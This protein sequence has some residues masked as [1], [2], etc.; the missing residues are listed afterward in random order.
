MAFF[1]ARSGREEQSFA[2]LWLSA[3]AFAPDRRLSE[4]PVFFHPPRSARLARAPGNSE[5]GRARYRASS[6]EKP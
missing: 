2:C 5:N 4:M 1:R 3:K 6:E